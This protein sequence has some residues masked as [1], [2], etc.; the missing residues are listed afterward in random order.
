MSTVDQLLYAAAVRRLETASA[1]AGRHGVA[2]A[3]VVDDD[4]TPASFVRGTVDFAVAVPHEERA[5][6]H[7]SFTR[8]V[9]LAG[10]PQSVRT[11][12]PARSEAAGLAWYGPAPISAW[13]NLSRLLKAFHGPAPVDVPD[14]L[15][16]PGGPRVVEAF[17]AVDAVSARDYLV[18]VHHL[19]AEAALRGLVRS[20]DTV[21]ITHRPDLDCSDVRALLDPARAGTVQTRITHDDRDPDRLRLYAVLTS[22]VERGQPC[23]PNAS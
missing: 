6:W 21:R 16:V 2:V 10:R 11:R 18:H 4:F 23:R 19:F 14:T 12:H 9:F 13:K 5:A 3:V 8:T 20:G 1:G 22:E 17:V 7:R 15:L